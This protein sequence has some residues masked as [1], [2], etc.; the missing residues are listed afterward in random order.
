MATPTFGLE[1]LKCKTWDLKVSIHC[2]G[3][4]RKVKKVLQ[5]IDGVYTA[6]VDSQ[7]QKVTVTGNVEVE[8]LIKKLI[9]TGKHAEI[10]HEKESATV[11]S[12]HK[13]TD[14]NTSQDLNHDHKKGRKKSN[15]QTEGAKNVEKS[16]ENT[17]NGVQESPAVKNKSSSSE[18]GGKKKKNKG[19]NGENGRNGSGSGASSGGAAGTGYQTQGVGMGQAVGPSN[20]CPTQQHF[21]PFSQGFNIP[22]V[23]ASSYSMSNPRE[24]GAPFYYVLPSPAAAAAAAYANPSRYQVTPLDSLYYFSDENVDG[25]FIM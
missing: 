9:K 25:C 1:P 15:D 16:P 18:S 17:T 23:Y 13:Q 14:P 21:V 11:K 20:P 8:T 4:K 3:C 6:T 19:V 12:M 10:W 24:S 5:S 7:Q 2:Q 22:Q